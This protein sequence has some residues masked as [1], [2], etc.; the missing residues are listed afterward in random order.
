MENIP[1]VFLNPQF[2]EK[3]KSTS[4]YLSLTFLRTSLDSPFAFNVRLAMARD[5]SH[6]RLFGQCSERCQR[7]QMNRRPLVVEW[8][9]LGLG[10]DATHGISNIIDT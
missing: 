8:G 1:I 5:S 2:W 10:L 4:F 9:F 7:G 6:W 3:R